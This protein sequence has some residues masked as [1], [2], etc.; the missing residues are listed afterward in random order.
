[1]L[2]LRQAILGGAAGACAWLWAAREP[3]ADSVDAYVISMRGGSRPRAEVR[4]RFEVC[5][6]PI[7]FFD[8]VDGRRVQATKRFDAVYPWTRGQAGCA[9]SHMKLWRQLAGRAPAA[10]TLV[11]EDDAVPV[12]E[13]QQALEG[14]LRELDGVTDVDLVFLGH[15]FEDQGARWRRSARLRHSVTPRCT[16]AYLVS[17][18]GVRKLAQWARTARLQQPVDE[19]LARACSERTL[20][21]LSA[22]P[23][24]ARQGLGESTINNTPP[25]V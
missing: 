6:Q 23:P 3:F 2:T 15:C 14:V 16:H 11:F 21:C 18:R 17:A 9:L 13:W 25:L 1:M 7:S 4:R 19:E 24:L 10:W 5:R 20:T 8:A 22:W 12:A